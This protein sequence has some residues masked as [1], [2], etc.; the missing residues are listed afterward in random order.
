MLSVSLAAPQVTHPAQMANFE[1]IVAVDNVYWRWTTSS[2]TDVGV[3]FRDALA[4][5]TEIISRYCTLNVERV[6]SRIAPIRFSSLGPGVLMQSHASFVL[7]D[8]IWVPKSLAIERETDLVYLR[9]LLQTSQYDIQ[10][11][12]NTGL[13]LIVGGPQCA[14]SG[15]DTNGASYS[16]TTLL[17][18]EL[19]HG[20]GFYSLVASQQGGGYQGSISLYDSLLRFTRNGSY[21]FAESQSVQGAYGNRLSKHTL[22]IAEHTV[23]NPSNFV[24]G[25]SL[26]HLSEEK[27]L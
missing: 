14:W 2:S 18:H 15:E 5:A 23:Y 21:V 1:S 6:L 9:Q 20:L 12:V 7:Q 10:I 26:S 11:T 27:V 3:H 22:S 4:R 13:D 8:S 24:Q 25:K 16:T 17:L 19:L